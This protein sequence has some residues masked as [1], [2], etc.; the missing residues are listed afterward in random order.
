MKHL[1]EYFY[2]ARSSGN[3]SPKHTRESQPKQIDSKPAEKKHV[4]FDLESKKPKRMPDSRNKY[5]LDSQINPGSVELHQSLGPE[6]ERVI[7]PSAFNNRLRVKMS[8]S[9]PPVSHVKVLESIHDLND[10]HYDP[11]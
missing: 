11:N 10:T 7:K 4:R 1:S 3:E 6:F 8:A 5:P 9:L 2:S